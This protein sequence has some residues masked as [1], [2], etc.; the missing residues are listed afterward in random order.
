MQASV[1]HELRNPLASLIYKTS[2]LKRLLRKNKKVIKALNRL[3]S[4]EEI[5]KETRRLSDN[6]ANFEKCGRQIFAVAQ[7]IDFFIHDMLDF[8]VLSEKSE[9]FT[10]TSVKFDLRETFNFVKEIFFENIAAKQLTLDVEYHCDEKFEVQSDR[11]RFLQVFINLVSNA[12][13]FTPFRGQIRVS[14]KLINS[15]SLLV[16]SIKDTGIGIAKKDRAKL[17][18][19]FGCIQNEEEQVNTKGI[20]LGLVISQMIVKRFQGTIDFMSE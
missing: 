2:E 1:S 9:N 15:R 3:S 7:L 18:Q 16:V 13:K 20:G 19:L 17:F 10:K 8:S 12:I 6:D 14:F 5:A 4:V 11:R